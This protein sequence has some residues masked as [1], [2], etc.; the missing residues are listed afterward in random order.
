[1]HDFKPLKLFS[2]IFFLMVALQCVL[3]M[4]LGS[5]FLSALG[6]FFVCINFVCFGAALM[7]LL[8]ENQK[9]RQALAQSREECI[10]IKKNADKAMKIKDRFLANMSHEIRNPMNGII[11]MMH[12]LLDSDLDEEQKRYSNIVYNSARALLTIVN[13]ILD[14]SKIE[15]GKL[16]IDSRDFDLE[17]AIKDIVSL[18]ELQARQKGIEFSYSIEG[19]VP[20]LLKGDI[21]R[22]RQVINNITGNAIKFTD[23]GEVTLNITVQSDSKTKAVLYFSVEDTGIGMKEDQIENLFKPFTQAD[24][25]ITK[26][27]G[28][29]GLGLA[30][31]KL[32]VEKM[33]GQMGAQSIEMIGSTFWFT[34]PLEKQSEQAASVDPFAHNIDDCRVL[35]FSDGSSLGINFENNL[36]TLNIN[37]E[38]AFDDTEAL[39]MLKW[40]YDENQ[41]FFLVIM[42]TKEFD[43]TA[44][45]LGRKIRQ[46]DMFKHTRLMLLTSIGKKGDAKRFEDAGFSAFLSKPVEGPLLLDAIKSVLSRP[47]AQGAFTLPIITKYSIVEKK[48]HLRHILI[49]DDIETN[50]LTARALIGKH[51][52]QIDEA[53]NGVIAVQKHKDNAYDL[54]LMD[55]QMP[56]MDGFE[57]TRRIR[58]HEAR[59][60]KEPVPI[61]AMTGNAFESDRKKC[62]EAGMNDFIAKPVEPDMLKQVISAYLNNDS[63][64]PKSVVDDTPED[65]ESLVNMAVCGSEMD[66][67]EQISETQVSAKNSDTKS[68]DREKLSERFG[69]DQELI[70]AVLEAFFLEA[71]ELI[72]HIQTAVQ[73]NDIE[74]VRLKA[75]A[76]KGSSA[77]IN[78]ELLRQ[79][80]LELETEAKN[81]KTELFAQRCAQLQDEYEKFLE[82]VNS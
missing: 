37:Y 52:Y 21:G 4:K 1:M 58:E 69:N 33:G 78:A 81:Q 3:F 5:V 79:A 17:V 72:D 48:K 80:A 66:L 46:D 57:A 50:L 22:I 15:A 77:N 27:F 62:L 44:E 10:Q 53:R 25:S 43:V 32:L 41:P 45:A 30:I 76:L 6:I 16:E 59:L 11:G 7:I 23:S 49:V 65:F 75:H 20:C 19:K 24:L 42:E 61:I 73:N 12:V 38:Q 39:E 8:K 70:E 18:P 40:S 9:D 54:I 36:N 51:G 14:L 82:D 28:G 2:G 63:Y 55:C 47:V 13:D 64:L 68:F 67:S 31:S 74:T 26:K 60:N 29:T 56:E 35:V 71:P 34:L